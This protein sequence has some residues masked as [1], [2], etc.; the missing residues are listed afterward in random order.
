MSI[1]AMMVVLTHQALQMQLQAASPQRGNP[2]AF[3]PTFDEGHD[4]C[5]CGYDHGVHHEIHHDDHH[6]ELNSQRP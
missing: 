1:A 5:L 4:V 2:R 3:P 6:D